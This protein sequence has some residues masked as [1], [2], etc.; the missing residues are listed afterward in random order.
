MSLTPLAIQDRLQVAQDDLV[1]QKAM[2]LTKTGEQNDARLRKAAKDFEGF[3]MGQ[4]FKSMY[5]SVPKSDFFGDASASRDIFMG[6]YIDEANKQ[7]SMGEKGIAAIL[8]KQLAER[9]NKAGKHELEAIAQ[10]R[11]EP[12]ENL[13]KAI[14]SLVENPDSGSSTQTAQDILS[15]LHALAR[16]L[17]DNKSSDFGMRKHPIFK[18]NKFH[19]G[20]DYALPEGQ[21][22]AVPVAGQ[23]VFAAENGG[24]GNTV[25][26]DHGHGISSLYA[27]LS[28]LGVRE[29][30]Q[31]DKGQ[32]IGKVGSTGISTGSHLHFEVR[33]GKN[34]IDPKHLAA[35]EKTAKAL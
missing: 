15:E 6:L 21:D 25:I 33:N 14:E 1:L 2:S 34:P 19:H 35:L 4:M 16:E 24:Y 7:N 11:H 18:V 3:M 17:E 10:T 26:I 8:Y 27:H 13:S 22:L 29:G 9:Q 23:V 20:V 32:I 12:Q 30:Q 31:I 5:E 28:K